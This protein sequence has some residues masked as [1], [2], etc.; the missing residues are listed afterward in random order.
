MSVMFTCLFSQVFLVLS[1]LVALRGCSYPKIALYL[2]KL[3]SMFGVTSLARS[4]TFLLGLSWASN[5]LI[6]LLRGLAFYGLAKVEITC[7]LEFVL[8]SI[9]TLPF[10]WGLGPYPKVLSGDSEFSKS[11]RR[12][13]FLRE[14]IFFRG[15]FS[16]IGDLARGSDVVFLSGECVLTFSGDSLRT[17]LSELRTWTRA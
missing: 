10:F 3:L 15:E 6:Y 1:K 9:L 7:S 8:S 17:V 5:I 11:A 4:A 12:L 16:F 13:C 14:P 2:S